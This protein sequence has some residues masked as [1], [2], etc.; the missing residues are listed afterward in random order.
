MKMKSLITF[1]SSNATKETS[2]FSLQYILS[3]VSNDLNFE[4]LLCGKETLKQKT[5]NSYLIIYS[6]PS[7]YMYF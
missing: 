6:W 3:I 2:L 4:M 7:M 1:I 5:A